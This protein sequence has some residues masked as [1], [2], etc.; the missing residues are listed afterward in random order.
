MHMDVSLFQIYVFL[1]IV[2]IVYFLWQWAIEPHYARSYNRNMHGSCYF[3]CENHKP[4]W[5]LLLSI[6]CCAWYVCGQFHLKCFGR[7][8]NTKK[9]ANLFMNT[10]RLEKKPKNVNKRLNP[11]E[12][13]ELRSTNPITVFTVHISIYLRD[14]KLETANQFRGK[15]TEICLM[16]SGLLLLF[17]VKY[18]I[19]CAENQIW[20][21]FP[22]KR[23]H[24]N[25]LVLFF[26]LKVTHPRKKRGRIIKD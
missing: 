22:V 7:K 3:R 2:S 20:I 8:R 13:N 10:K 9:W 23:L 11:P 1:C 4:L 26:P 18:E 16:E 6:P 12:K 14:F 25:F 15:N 5:L 24:S 17:K 21:I 19:R